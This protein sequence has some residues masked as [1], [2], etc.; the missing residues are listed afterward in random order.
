[1]NVYILLISLSFVFT[2][3]GK[4][5]LNSKEMLYDKFNN[6]NVLKMSTSKIDNND[7]ITDAS[8]I[9]LNSINEYKNDGYFFC[10]RW[11]FLDHIFY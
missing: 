11:L 1:M 9:L 8:K 7:S 3:G 4:P 6:V 5:I 2:T 10:F